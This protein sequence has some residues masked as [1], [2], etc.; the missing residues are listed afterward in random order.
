MVYAEVR[1]APEQHLEAGLTLD[2]VVEASC[3][4][5][6]EGVGRGRA[7]GRT[8]RIGALLTAMRHAARSREI[9][10]LAVRFRDRGVVGFDI[11][12]AEAGL[13]AQPAPRRLRVHARQQ[14]AFHHSRG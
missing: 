4:G 2:E 5:S 10:E 12:G 14:C 13:S 6:R 8:I 7:R 3:A 1:F 11:A 9:A